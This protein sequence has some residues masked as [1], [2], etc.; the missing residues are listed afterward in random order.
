VETAGK[1]D[2]QDRGVSF[3]ITVRPLLLP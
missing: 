3:R 1:R 2:L